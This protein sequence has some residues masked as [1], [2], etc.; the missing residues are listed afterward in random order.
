MSVGR[1]PLSKLKCLSGKLCAEGSAYIRLLSLFNILER[2]RLQWSVVL[3]LAIEFSYQGFQLTSISL[4]NV[5]TEG[6]Q[7]SLPS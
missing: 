3:C 4:R 7:K 6:F 5:A 2:V 1:D